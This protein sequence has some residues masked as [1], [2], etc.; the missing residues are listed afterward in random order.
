MPGPVC[1]NALADS[2]KQFHPL[3][4]QIVFFSHQAYFV[5]GDVDMLNIVQA[6][7]P[8]NFLVV[9]PAVFVGAV[10]GFDEDLFGSFRALLAKAV[11][12][13]M[14]DGFI[15]IPGQHT[16]LYAGIQEQE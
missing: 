6:A 15:I 7:L 16:C 8:E 11:A 10:I 5:A 2:I 12:D 14:H 3:G 1:R 13:E 4:F 9:L